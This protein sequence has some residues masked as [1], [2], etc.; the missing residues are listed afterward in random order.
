[1]DNQHNYELDEHPPRAA[2]FTHSGD[3][4]ILAVL[5]EAETTS[6]RES[7]CA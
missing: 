2:V 7:R 1:M 5:A 4:L 6:E 3:A